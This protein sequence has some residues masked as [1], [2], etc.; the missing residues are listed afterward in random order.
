MSDFFIV[1]RL[2]ILGI[3]GNIAEKRSEKAM[4]KF[5]ADLIFKFRLQNEDY[6]TI[7]NRLSKKTSTI[8]TYCCRHALTDSNLSHISECCYCH[9]PITQMAKGKKRVFCN[10]K[11][12][13]AWRREHHMLS[14]PVYRHVCVGCGSAFETAGNKAQKYCSRQC[15][16]NHR[17]G[18]AV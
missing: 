18:N 16:L 2:I 11:C 17:K 6:K 9:K 10:D 15:Y 13:S 7:A 12:R 5:E 8:S 14:E 1:F 4:T 3:R